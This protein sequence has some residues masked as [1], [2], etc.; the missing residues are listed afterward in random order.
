MRPVLTIATL[1][2]LLAA[3]GP[4]PKEIAFD[5]DPSATVHTLDA[6]TLPAAKVLDTSGNP[7]ADAKIAWSVEPEGVATIDAATGTL[8]PTAD[9]EVKVT[10]KLGELSK[11]YVLTVSLPDTVQITT[12]E[13]ATVAVG[14]QVALAASV[15]ADGT[16]VPGTTVAWA[17]ADPA[18]ATI[19]E[20]GNVTGVAAGETTVTAT[21]G[22]LSAA[23][24]I[25]V[26]AAD[27][28]AA[29]GTEAAAQ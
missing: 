22:A 15:L 21:S 27:A 11:S 17:S 8:T 24:K 3:C 28:T 9:G 14:A 26:A 19:D 16:T 2:A 12:G 10:A 25:V 1:V 20:A 6:V 29:A 23:A 7:M 5:A 18:I 4:T 13:S